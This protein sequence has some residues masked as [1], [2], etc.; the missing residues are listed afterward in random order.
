LGPG[1]TKS[2]L[3]TRF[4]MT[5]PK[6]QH[7]ADRVMK[8]LSHVDDTVKAFASGKRSVSRHWLVGPYWTPSWGTYAHK[9]A[10]RTW[11]R[12]T[13]LCSFAL[14]YLP[15]RAS[16]DILEKM[17]NEESMRLSAAIHVYIC[18]LQAD[19][20]SLYTVRAYLQDLR[21]LSEWAGPA[22]D[23]RAIRATTL[24]TY[25]SSQPD[26]SN[27]QVP[28]AASSNRA[29]CAVRALFRFLEEAVSAPVLKVP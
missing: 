8:I 4:Y 20:K 28:A 18:Q 25:F 5:T 11:L 29:K 16:I 3:K 7:T 14:T 21:R 13:F 24:T 10:S 9:Q 12:A 27:L 17:G 23:V 19:R 2:T 15:F 6:S 22:T 26:D 1:P